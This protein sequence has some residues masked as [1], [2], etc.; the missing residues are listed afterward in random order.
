MAIQKL[1]PFRMAVLER[2]KQI[3]PGKVVR[4]KDISARRCSRVPSALHF[5]VNNGYPDLP[6]HRVVNSDLSLLNTKI[7][8]QESKLRG[9]GVNLRVDTRFR[10]RRAE[11]PFGSYEE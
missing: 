8:N 2:V 5:L 3:P 9:E 10:L 11:I 7:G 6:W 4:C 1:T